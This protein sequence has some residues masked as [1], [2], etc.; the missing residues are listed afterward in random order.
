MNIVT[1]NRQHGACTV[2][3]FAKRDI[4]TIDI[5]INMVFTKSTFEDC[6]SFID[7]F[8]F[9]FY[10]RRVHCFE[11]PYTTSKFCPSHFSFDVISSLN[12]SLSR[13]HIPL[14]CEVKSLVWPPKTFPIIK[15]ST[16][17]NTSTKNPNLA[18]TGIQT[19]PNL[20]FMSRYH[21]FFA[22]SI[23]LAI[24]FSAMNQCSGSMMQG[25]MKR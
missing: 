2:L 17:Q 20:L 16:S 10:H 12:V 3:R 15:C 23:L 19:N 7:I 9:D 5:S 22:L 4:V 24:A 13:F 14:N 25:H 21:I 8:L 6:A 1:V 18:L 11:M